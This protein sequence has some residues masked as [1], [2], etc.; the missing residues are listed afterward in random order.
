MRSPVIYSPRPAA[1]YC[2][3]TLPVCEVGEVLKLE[4]W[5]AIWNLFWLSVPTLDT[6]P[7]AGNAWWR[8]YQPQEGLLAA[9]IADATE[10]EALYR[11]LMARPS[12]FIEF[13]ERQDHGIFDTH[14]IL[15]DA[16]VETVTRRAHEADARFFDPLERR[17]VTGR[18]GNVIAVQFPSRKV[19]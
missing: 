1:D 11:K 3:K 16:W 6:L 7:D 17:G 14:E 13:W 19:A 4:Q 9:I 5:P 10:D 18:V 8:G 2:I 12:K 15:G